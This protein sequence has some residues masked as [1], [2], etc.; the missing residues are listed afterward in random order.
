MK[1]T[2]NEL[3]KKKPSDL[4]KRPGM[5][6][7]DEFKGV[8]DLP[9]DERRMKGIFIPL[10]KI[11]IPKSLFKYR[12]NDSS[13]RKNLKDDTV[14]LAKPS[15]F[16]DPYDCNIFIDNV[17]YHLRRLE[18]L[19]GMLTASELDEASEK[20]RNGLTS[21]EICEQW[22][23]NRFPDG[24]I[25][26]KSAK[27]QMDGVLENHH[28]QLDAMKDAS[29][30]C[31]FCERLDSPLMW[32]HYSDQHRGFCIEY[33]FKDAVNFSPLDFFL[34]PVMYQ[35]KMVDCF[36]NLGSDNLSHPYRLYLINLLKSE[37]WSYER[38]WRIVMFNVKNRVQKVPRAKAVYLGSHIV[39]NT[40]GNIEQ[41]LIGK[42][43]IIE[44][45]RDKDI[46]VY[47]M[48]HSRSNFQMRVDKII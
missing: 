19:K 34:N 11:N 43:E 15:S 9:F 7:F 17:S 14:W 45:C 8:Y 46:P 20:I 40:V 41:A 26:A 30:V 1:N 23:L 22:Y 29:G 6:W 44:I 4:F 16:N 12:G 21:G 33:D 2:I 48:N 27:H 10:K 37:D 31:S 24:I 28:K 39:G 35:D 32:S 5:E 18:S 42:E 47:Q 38:E 13:S 25:E 36:D 3:L